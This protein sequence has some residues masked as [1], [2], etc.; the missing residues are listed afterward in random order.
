MKLRPTASKKLNH[1]FGGN[2]SE[3]ARFDSHI[4]L[5]KIR[6]EGF[7]ENVH[8]KLKKGNE[9][10][11]S[12]TNEIVTPFKT[13]KREFDDR[14]LSLN[15]LTSKSIRDYPERR[16]D[17]KKIKNLMKSAIRNSALKKS[18]AELLA[19]SNN[20]NSALLGRRRSTSIFA[21]RSDRKFFSSTRSKILKGGFGRQIRQHS[22]QK[23]SKQ[24]AKNDI[25]EYLQLSN[26]KRGQTKDMK[27]EG[28]NND[29][30]EADSEK[31][32]SE[33][34][35]KVAAIINFSKVPRELKKIMS[36]SDLKVIS[37]P[38]KDN[39]NGNSNIDKTAGVESKAHASSKTQKARVVSESPRKSAETKE[40]SKASVVGKLNQKQEKAFQ[41][42]QH[43]GSVVSKNSAAK[44]LSNGNRLRD[45]NGSL[46]SRNQSEKSQ[47]LLVKNDRAHLL[48]PE[49]ELGPVVKKGKKSHR[50]KHRRSGKDETEQQELDLQVMRKTNDGINQLYEA[51]KGSRTYI[52]CDLRYFNFDF[53]VDKL[54]H[55]DGKFSLSF[56]C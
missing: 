4:S 31:K 8:K 29:D 46:F 37:N 47:K 22:G 13:R 24:E 15:P 40:S 41:E 5:D 36:M 14:R 48:V 2:K 1:I 6:E 11:Y 38:L 39:T 7:F 28:N 50:N 23:K 19:D 43:T 32:F 3:H 52:N 34:I 25:S 18:E 56:Q 49:E 42:E 10:M 21:R 20:S 44:D 27:D 33:A 55:F 51:H 16:M 12:E 45:L 30:E 26:Q 9:L 53:L 35:S 17:A 54:G